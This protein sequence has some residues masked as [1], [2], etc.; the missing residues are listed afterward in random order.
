MSEIDLSRSADYRNVT[1]FYKGKTDDEIR[2]ALDMQRG[3]MVSIMQNLSHDF[4]KASA[5]RNSNAFGMRKL[6]FLNPE[7]P[8]IPDAKEGIKK[9]DRRGSLGTQNYEH[10]EHH[11]IIDYPAIFKQLHQ[12]G[13]TIYAIDNTPGYNPQSLYDV[14]FPAKSAF[15]FGEEKLGLADDLIAAADAMVYIPQYGSVRSINVGV[16]H[17]V[18]AAFYASQHQPHA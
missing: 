10:I 18:I 13:Y 15:L 12:E 3:E 1:D 6:I 4:N 2:T 11:R 16:A 14:K 5:V 17:G 8:A 9:W 7:N